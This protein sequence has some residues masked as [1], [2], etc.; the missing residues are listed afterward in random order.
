MDT[1]KR[2]R[3][4]AKGKQKTP[5][6]ERIRRKTSEVQASETAI[7]S[8]TV[9]IHSKELLLQARVLIEAAGNRGVSRTYVSIATFDSKPDWVDST[10]NEVKRQLEGEGFKVDLQE[11]VEQGFGSNRVSLAISW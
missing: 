11:H 10:A 6:V 8:E 1:A 7:R 2:T 3:F 4:E 5:F 9:K